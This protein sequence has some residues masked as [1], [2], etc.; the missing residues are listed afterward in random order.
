MAVLSPLYEQLSRPAPIICNCGNST[1]E[2]ISRGCKFDSLATSWLPLVCRDD[3][4]TEEFD[5][6]GPGPDGEWIY[7]L[8]Q[9]LSEPIR[10]HQVAMLADAPIMDDRQFWMTSEWHTAHCLFYWRK[11]L[12]STKR[13][14]SG[15]RSPGADKIEETF[16]DVIHVDH[17]ALEFLH[18]RKPGDLAVIGFSGFG[19]PLE[20]FD[21]AEFLAEQIKSTHASKGKTMSG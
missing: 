6:S 14:N 21:P 13:M 12:R 7:Y 1:A 16:S 5:R 19:D 17:C 8:N 20:G 3:A 9:N 10:L 15:G 18:R 2:A 11:S 4:L